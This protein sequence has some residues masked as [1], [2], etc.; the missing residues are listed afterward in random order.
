MER[1]NSLLKITQSKWQA[2][3]MFKPVMSDSKTVLTH[4][5]ELPPRAST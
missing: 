2:E 5:T 3:L 4:I 1:L